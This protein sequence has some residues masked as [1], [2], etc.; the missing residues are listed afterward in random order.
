MAAPVGVLDVAAYILE[1]SGPM[2]TWKLQKLC[3]YSQAWSLVWDDA[4]LFKEQIEA[5]AHGPV[6]R[7]LYHK[8]RGQ[9][10]IVKVRGGKST[11]LNEDQ[12]DTI[13]AV[14]GAYGHW[15]G[16]ALSRQTH[17]ESPWR[18]AREKAGLQLGERGS[19]KI[20]QDRMAEYYGSLFMFMDDDEEEET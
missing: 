16:A 20:D 6:I 2:S 17:R 15:P 13:D 12:R 9:F 8:H 1:K 11:K 3:Y 4:P 10:D 5:W 7:D 18:E 19:A 14:L